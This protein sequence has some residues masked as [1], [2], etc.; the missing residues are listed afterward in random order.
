MLKGGGPLT[1]RSPYCPLNRSSS[2]HGPLVER[3]IKAIE[4]IFSLGSISSPPL[5]CGSP[6]D[7]NDS[8]TVKA[9]KILNFGQCEL[10]YISGTHMPVN[11]STR[12]HGIY[13]MSF[14]F[15]NCK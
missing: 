13:G 8:I 15:T 9:H 5:K 10:A 11:T 12:L 7:S 14:H 1:S 3:G 2:T 6:N 4:M